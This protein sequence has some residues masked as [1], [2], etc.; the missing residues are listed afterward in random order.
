MSKKIYIDGL[1]EAVATLQGLTGAE[2]KKLLEQIALK[3]PTMAQKLKNKLVSFEDLRFMTPKMLMELLREVQ[4][5]D[6]AIAMRVGSEELRKFVLDNVSKN[7]KFEIIEILNGPRKKL[8]E[9]ALAQEDIL[10]VL[11]KKLE[12]GEIV[13]DRSGADKYV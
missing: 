5:K 10:K 7:T 13:L 2:Q 8:S 3:D 4:I 1:K 11:R 6:L 9:V 12:R